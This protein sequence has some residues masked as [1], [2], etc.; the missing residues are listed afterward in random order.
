MDEILADIAADIIRNANIYVDLGAMDDEMEDE[1]T[2][3]GVFYLHICGDDPDGDDDYYETLYIFI[4]YIK[5]SYEDHEKLIIQV[6]SDLSSI[7][8]YHCTFLDGETDA[9][10]QAFIDSTKRDASAALHRY[11]ESIAEEMSCSK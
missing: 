6:D 11:Y 2:Y 1:T 10:A 7:V 3:R 5:G 8:D 9:E 4:S